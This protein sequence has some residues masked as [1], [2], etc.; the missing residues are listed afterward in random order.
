MQKHGMQ[1]AKCN[2]RDKLSVKRQ[3]KTNVA[4][5]FPSFHVLTT[6]PYQN[7]YDYEVPSNQDVPLPLSSQATIRIGTEICIHLRKPSLSLL[8]SHLTCL[9]SLPLDHPHPNHRLESPLPFHVHVLLL[10]GHS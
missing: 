1:N 7:K 2:E 5:G 3:G 6:A 10:L 4:A 8:N 9:R